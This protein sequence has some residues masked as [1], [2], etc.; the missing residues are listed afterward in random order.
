MRRRQWRRD[1]NNN[2]MIDA[3]CNHSPSALA[4]SMASPSTLRFSAGELQS[5]IHFYQIILIRSRSIR[6]HSSHFLVRLVSLVP[7]WISNQ[8]KPLRKS[9][10]GKVGIEVLILVFRNL[11]LWTEK[12]TI[13]IS[14]FL[15]SIWIPEWSR[16]EWLD[17]LATLLTSKQKLKSLI[18]LRCVSPSRDDGKCIRWF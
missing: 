16:S 18:F 13:K 2:L 11:H 3:S 8:L 15:C 7:N 17:S 1:A 14:N 5:H 12:E 6:S 10:S 9:G 4:T